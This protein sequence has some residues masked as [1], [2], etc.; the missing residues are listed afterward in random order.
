MFRISLLSS[1]AA[2]VMSSFCCFFT[3]E[4]YVPD[5]DFYVPDLP[6]PSPA[7][8]VMSRFGHFLAVLPYVPVIKYWITGFD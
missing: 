3:V 8:S 5:G 2:S 7:A 1:P 4:P 6:L